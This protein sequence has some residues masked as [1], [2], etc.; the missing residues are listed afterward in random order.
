M[1]SRGQ[2]GT[3]RSTSSMVLPSGSSRNTMAVCGPEGDA[4]CGRPQ[5]GPRRQ[6]LADGGIE[7]A[8]GEG[9]VGQASP[10]GQVLRRGCGRNLTSMGADELDA[11]T[12]R[13]EEQ[14]Q[15]DGGPESARLCDG[16]GQVD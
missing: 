10:A 8:D 4:G 11:F 12:A 1:A 3:V 6:Q 16:R 15:G 5:G 14:Y 2:V 13:G 7:V 9:E